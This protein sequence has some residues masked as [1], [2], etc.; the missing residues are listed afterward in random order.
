MA[1]AALVQAALLCPVQ[2]IPAVTVVRHMQGEQKKVTDLMT[3]VIMIMM[4]SLPQKQ[5]KAICGQDSP[6][7]HH[8]HHQRRYCILRPAFSLQ[9]A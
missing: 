2:Q 6:T 7:D 1:D 8:Q 3:I 9:S 4:T 5:M